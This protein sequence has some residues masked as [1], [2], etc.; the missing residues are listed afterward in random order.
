MQ[1]LGTV[2][3]APDPGKMAQEC[4]ENLKSYDYES[5][6]GRRAANKEA[7]R[8]AAEAACA[9]YSGGAMP[10]GICGGV[11][12][13]VAEIV[14]SIVEGI[15]DL[16]F[17]ESDESKRNRQKLAALTTQITVD[18]RVRAN[19]AI[20]QMMVDT[21]LLAMIDAWDASVP[22]E[23]GKLG[24][25]SLLT[26][27]WDESLPIYGGDG[28]LVRLEKLFD[29]PLKW[30]RYSNMI[31]AGY[32]LSDLGADIELMPRGTYEVY[33]FSTGMD[34]SRTPAWTSGSQLEESAAFRPDH[35][36][37][38][39]STLPV[40]NMPLVPSSWE[41]SELSRFIQYTNVGLNSVFPRWV[42]DMKKATADGTLF[43]VDAAT[44]RQAKLILE[45]TN[46]RELISAQLR[47][48]TRSNVLNYALLGAGALALGGAWAYSRKRG[49]R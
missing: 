15:G 33:A 27:E 36:P 37:G 11:G 49:K 41:P 44:S 18:Y 13:K 19:N 22:G 40:V 2:A 32:L 30:K 8:C 9:Y 42:D 14:G 20:M 35:K 38:I 34:V 12:E 48:E 43:V 23:S 7:G 26:V 24:G 45:E 25:G 4:A 10:A 47:G 21:A 31:P 29:S 3:G 16:L 46:Q 1:G 39:L 6:N 5:A 28:K 17:G